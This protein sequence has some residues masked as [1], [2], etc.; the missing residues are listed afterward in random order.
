M[1]ALHAKINIRNNISYQSE[2]IFAYADDI[3]SVGR[4]QAAVKGA[5]IINFEK[6]AR[7]MHLNI[8]MIQ[9]NACQQQKNYCR[10][11]PFTNTTPCIPLLTWDQRKYLQQMCLVL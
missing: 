11:S 5:V 8:I 4:S 1:P 6:T 3:D 2:Q 10:H 7:E 9:Q